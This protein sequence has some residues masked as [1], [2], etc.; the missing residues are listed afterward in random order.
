MEMDMDQ[1]MNPFPNAQQQQQQQQQQRQFKNGVMGGP[2]MNGRVPSAKEQTLL[3]QQGNWDSGIQSGVTT[4]APSISSRASGLEMEAD[5][6]METV[7]PNPKGNFEWNRMNGQFNQMNGSQLPFG[8]SMEEAVSMPQP[9]FGVSQPTAVDPSSPTQ[10]LQHAVDDLVN[11]HDDADVATVIPELI[12]LLNDEDQVVA[13]QAVTMVNQLSKNSRQA[14]IDYE[15]MTNN[16]ADSMVAAVVRVMCKTDYGET[17]RHTAGTLHNLSHHRQ[18]L[19]CISKCGGIAALVKLLSSDNESVLFYAIT[20]L[21]NLLLH[22]EGSKMAVR[23]SGGLQSMV[24]LLTRPN[25]KFLAIVTD[26]L[27]ILAYG[28]QESKAVILACGGPA[29][30]VR[31]MRLYTYEKLLWTTSRVLKVL[32]V[33]PA[34]KPAI[35]AA[36]G[37][38]ALGIHLAS[39]SHRLVQNCLWALRNLSD[40]ATKVG[41]IENLLGMLFQLL[42]SNDIDIVTC[43]AGILSNLT[44][45]NNHN[46]MVACQV[47]GVETLLALIA[48]V[49]DREGIVEPAVCTLRHLTSRHPHA[50]MAQNVVREQGGLPVVTRLLHPPSKWPLIKA[51]IGLLRNLVLSPQNNGPLREN[52]CLP[53]LM[54]LLIKA[55]QAAQRPPPEAGAAALDPVAAARP[56]V[57]DG[58]K[59][60]D[61]VEGIV[62]ALHIL[63]RDPANRVSIRAQNCIPLFVELLYSPSDK[64]QLVAAGVLC[65]LAQDKEGADIIEQDG[66]TAPLMELLHSKSQAVATYAAALLFRISE[67]KPAEYRKR[68][69]VAVD[70]ASNARGISGAAGAP[71]PPLQPQQPPTPQQQSQQQQQLQKGNFGNEEFSFGNQLVNKNAAFP[72]Q[73]N[74]SRQDIFDS[75]GADSFGAMNQQQQQQ[76][77]QQQLTPGV[78]PQPNLSALSI[79]PFPDLGSIGNAIEDF[80]F[81]NIQPTIGQPYGNLFD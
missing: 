62:G 51:T 16:P 42:G 28:H 80:S 64:V 20:T 3:W 39:D 15:M 48:N 49:Q 70:N 33:C 2:A 37:M 19:H 44:C 55:N 58:V 11:F 14:I 47:N 60:I 43:C 25:V 50:E 45:N 52:G 61:V 35:V 59:M 38:Q 6:D 76:R 18:G 23:M 71:G 75:N 29:E 68:L 30:L 36:G 17:A 9:S 72:N 56:V 67:D 8:D 74:G 81:E 63:A 78:H 10:M 53:K 4:N 77:Q 66:A 40:A 41:G 32:S 69:S 24:A 46:K 22:Q 12:Q 34:N 1:G 5:D 26:C 27:Q 57:V 54:Q 65:E 13:H 79:D 31:I 21:H 73:I 7:V